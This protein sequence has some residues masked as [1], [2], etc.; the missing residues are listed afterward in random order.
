MLMG[1]LSGAYT[2]C[3]DKVKALQ[4]VYIVDKRTLI[5][6]HFFDGMGRASGG[7][8]GDIADL[9][10]TR[11]HLSGL[12]DLINNKLDD[13]P[14]LVSLGRG[15]NRSHFSRSRHVW[16]GLTKKSDSDY[17]NMI[18]L[19][20]AYQ[21]ISHIQ[22]NGYRLGELQ[23]ATKVEKPLSMEINLAPITISNSGIDVFSSY[24]KVLGVSEDKS[25]SFAIGF[26][27]H[28]DEY[29]PYIRVAHV[30]GVQTGIFLINPLTN[31]IDSDFD[32][33]SFSLTKSAYSEMQ[34][35]LLQAANIQY[36][37][38]AECPYPLDGLMHI[39]W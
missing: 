11:L 5:M 9:L 26:T 6:P 32:S 36:I 30:S 10:L 18:V 25:V 24:D 35:M 37:P 14:I 7:Q 38:V 29:I 8:C 31:K 22:V 2:N 27:R 19:D 23:L 21:E 39:E 34:A 1:E 4:T 12:I 15:N 16:I 17:K 13:D 3:L 28:Q 33:G 20:A